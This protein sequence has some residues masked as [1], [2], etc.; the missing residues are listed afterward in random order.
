MSRRNWSSGGT[1]SATVL[2]HEVF[3]KLGT[4]EARLFNDKSHFL[5]TSSLAMRQIVVNYLRHKYAEKRQND[6]ETLDVPHGSSDP[7]QMDLILLD[8]ALKELATVDERMVKIVE[9]RVFGGF[10]IDE[11]ADAMGVSS[12][13]IDRSW[14][15][16]K[17]LL[18]RKR[19][20]T[21][22]V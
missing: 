13:T 16:A 15:K 3:L 12:R 14:S 17:L 2:V 4:D 5:A 1:L 9:A 21:S 6:S 19:Q 18:A 11:I 20:T 7:D 22:G 10:S 8:Q